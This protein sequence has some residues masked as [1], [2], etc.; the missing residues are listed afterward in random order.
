MLI[1]KA[2]YM[3][4]RTLPKFDVLGDTIIKYVRVEMVNK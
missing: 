3:C 1:W 4:I 2:C